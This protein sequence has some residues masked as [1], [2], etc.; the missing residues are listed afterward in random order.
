MMDFDKQIQLAQEQMAQKT[1]LESAVKSL[2]QQRRE[3]DRKIISL[4]V[5]L[6]DEEADVQKLE[7][8]SLSGFFLSI[9]GKLEDKLETERQEARA[10][11]MKYD[12]AVQDLEALDAQL[13]QQRSALYKVT[14]CEQ[15]YKQLMEDKRNMLKQAGSPV[16]D[17][18]LEL[19]DQITRCKRDI[20]ELDEAMT[21]GERAKSTASGVLSKLDT[22]LDYS[23]W[24]MVGGGLFADLAKHEILDEAQ[25]LVNTLQVNLRRFKTELADVSISSD[26][27]VTV[28]GFLHFADYFFDG[29]L[30]DWAVRD[31]IREAQNRIQSTS[32]QI[33]RVL[34]K[35]KTKRGELLTR[36]AV[37]EAQVEDLVKNTQL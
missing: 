24:D 29:L 26:I 9:L 13:S 22:A 6:R 1:H 27:Q 11:R 36:Q 23:T 35:L 37:L 14:G 18:I 34:N 30:V 2:E 15:R 4:K 7:S 17:R 16:T 12:A 31:R 32:Y 5:A 19:T 20:R 8:P 28:D 10:A 25:N 21:A 33:E 3:L